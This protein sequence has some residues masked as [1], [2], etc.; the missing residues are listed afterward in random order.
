MEWLGPFIHDHLIWVY[1]ILFF[2][3]L[4]EGETIVIVL[5]ALAS[6]QGSPLSVWLIILLALV[7]SLTG[8]NLWFFFGRHKGQA[9][10][11]KRPGWKRQAEKVYRIFE[12]HQDWLMLGFRFLYGVR[13]VTP[14]A[15]GVS[16]VSARKFVICN[17]IGATAWAISF[18]LAGYY[19]KRAVEEYLGYHKWHVLGGVLLLVFV[20]WL[21]RTIIRAV[22]ARMNGRRATS[23]GLPKPGVEPEK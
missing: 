15:L 14:L 19:G 10:L 22:R 8:D 17:I 20:H 11:A 16:S 6:E 3:T 9:F 23:L 7:G 1:V 12:H 13:N 18:T 21:T 4:I 5:G 2:W